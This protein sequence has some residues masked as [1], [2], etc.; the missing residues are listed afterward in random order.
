MPPQAVGDA[1]PDAEAGTAVALAP[2][3]M[4]MMSVYSM[5]A[6]DVVIWAAL[7]LIMA[8]ILRT[9]D[10]GLWWAFGLIAGVGLQ[11]KLSVAFLGFGLLL[12]L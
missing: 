3:Y 8:R 11:N 7:M 10:S 6:L 5:N 12:A 1:E 4:S 2:Q 9:G